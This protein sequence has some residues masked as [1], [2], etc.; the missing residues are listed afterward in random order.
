[1]CAH[2]LGD[3][4]LFDRDMLEG[5]WT[6]YTHLWTRAIT[7]GYT[8]GQIAHSIDT[9]RNLF[10]QEW[11][12]AA[13]WYRFGVYA[14]NTGVPTFE[15]PA[16]AHYIQASLQVFLRVFASNLTT[17]AQVSSHARYIVL[18]RNNG[19]D[20][21]VWKDGAMLWTVDISTIDLA[22]TGIDSL[23]MSQD[24]RYLLVLSDTPNLLC[25]RG[26]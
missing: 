26:D 19:V 16:L 1:M 8:F 21:E 14:L 13:N 22:A 25:F 23:T 5:N 24:G 3:E 11:R 4:V 12:D 9:L 15:S 20:L 2:Q 10:Y 18:M 6:T 17:I 7:N